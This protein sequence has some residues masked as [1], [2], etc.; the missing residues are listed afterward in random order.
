MKSNKLG[1]INTIEYYVSNKNCYA[2]FA[3]SEG[4][5][6]ILSEKAWHKMVYYDC[7]DAKLKLE[8]VCGCTKVDW[9][10]RVTTLTGRTLP[11]STRILVEL[12]GWVL[13]NRIIQNLC[14]QL[15]CLVHQ[16]FPC[17][18]FPYQCQENMCW[19]WQNLCHS[20]SLIVGHSLTSTTTDWDLMGKK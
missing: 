11:G 14:D 8:A 16:H 12:C 20:E 17:G 10:Q 3:D 1:F 9:F 5:N 19:R 13:A 4:F 7:N 2:N 15:P 6:I 18:F